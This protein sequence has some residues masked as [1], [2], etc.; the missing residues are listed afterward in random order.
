M[1]SKTMQALGIA[2]KYIAAHYPKFDTANMKLTIEDKGSTW[3]VTYELPEQYLG[4]APV[5][6]IEKNSL[7]VQKT[8]HTQ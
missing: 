5:V 8:Y 6:V 2:K 1:N 3:E 4:G 7:E